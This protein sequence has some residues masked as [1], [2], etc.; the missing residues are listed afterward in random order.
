[1][2]NTLQSEIDYIL[3][4]GEQHPQFNEAHKENTIRNPHLYETYNCELCDKP[5]KHSSNMYTCDDCLNSLPY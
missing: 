1:M 4:Q 3:R 5:F 2:K